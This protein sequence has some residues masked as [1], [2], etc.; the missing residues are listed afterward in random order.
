MDIY[1]A[2]KKTLPLVE[3]H[4]PQVFYDSAIINLEPVSF[5][6]GVFTLRIIKDFFKGTLIKRYLFEI[7]RCLRSVT[8]EEIDVQIISPRDAMGHT[9]EN[10]RIDSYKKTNLKPKY[11]FST[12]VKGKCN[13]LAYAGALAVAESPGQTVYNPLFL[14][15]GVGLGKT[16]L[17]QSIGNY[18]FEQNPEL[19]VLYN[20]A[21]AFTKEFVQGIRDNDM[22]PFKSRYRECDV[23][24]LDDIQFLAGKEGTQEEFFH[25]FNDLY[26][27]NKQLIF[28]SDLSPRDLTRLEKRL[29][30]RFSMGLPV[31]FTQPDY[32]TR[33]AI[34]EKKL[35]LENFHIPNDVKDYVLA[36][37][38]SNIRDLEGALNKIS[39]M[40]RLTNTSITM[41]LAKFA[42]RG[43]ITETVKK[44]ITVEHI[45]EVVAAKYNLSVD[46]LKDKKKTQSVVLPRQIAMYLCRKILSV[47][48]PAVGK[49]FGGRDHSTVIHG[50]IKIESEIE[51]DEALKIAINDLERSIRG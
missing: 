4:V 26:N 1:D 30:S 38:V 37:I 2:W 14:Y 36:N 11:V 48:L 21:E 29:T 8:E 39:A 49:K 27:E 33:A 46:D 35:Q 34:L 20:S 32:E 19:K 41:E 13:E 45:Q 25:T 9:V 23:L 16:H 18:V 10:N 15:G 42:L 28:T 43:Q 5:E 6:N 50:C 3:R 12:F 22:E 31:E 7:T 17:V 24:I 40:A 44:E 47:S 51:K